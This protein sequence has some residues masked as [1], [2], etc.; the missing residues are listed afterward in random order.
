MICFSAISWKSEL[1]ILFDV[2]GLPKE[3]FQY[4][5]LCKD[6]E[7]SDSEFIESGCDEENED[8]TWYPSESVVAEWKQVKD[9]TN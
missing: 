3:Q 8:Q 6:E 4:F 7:M 5:Q 9:K 2:V 1:N